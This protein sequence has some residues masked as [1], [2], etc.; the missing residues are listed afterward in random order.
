LAE[1]FMGISQRLREVLHERYDGNQ[2]AMAEAWELG[3]S[4]LSRWLNRRRVPD[5]DSYDFLCERLGE[6]VTE[7]HHLC[8]ADRS[9]RRRV[10]QAL[11]AMAR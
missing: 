10:A 11:T 6:T 5:P 3:E 4:T 2:K 9:R 8:Q 1:V 7:V